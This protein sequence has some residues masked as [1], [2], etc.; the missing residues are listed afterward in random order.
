MA[1]ATMAVLGLAVAGFGLAACS[2]TETPGAGWPQEAAQYAVYATRIPLYPGTKVED[3]MGADTLGGDPDATR[4]RMVWWCT[5]K[6][7]KDELRTWY[8]AKLPGAARSDTEDGHIVLTLVPE[9]AQP[10]EQMG[11]LVEADGKYRVFERTRQ[12]KP[13]T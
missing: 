10:N 4:Y 5:A 3:A 2:N 6:A 13:G 9:G 8:E 12:K 7:S 11:V 1:R